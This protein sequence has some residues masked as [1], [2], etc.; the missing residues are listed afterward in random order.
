[1]GMGIIAIVILRAVVMHV[2]AMARDR[3]CKQAKYKVVSATEPAARRRAAG[4]LAFLIHSK[5]WKFKYVQDV[6]Y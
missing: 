6:F 2:R 5:S 1:M 4:L 3:S